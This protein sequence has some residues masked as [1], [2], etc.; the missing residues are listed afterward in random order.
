VSQTTLF[1]AIEVIRLCH[2]AMSSFIDITRDAS[3]KPDTSDTRTL[4]I[5]EKIFKKMYALWHVTKN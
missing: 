3:E 4:H 2:I 5:S 1:Q